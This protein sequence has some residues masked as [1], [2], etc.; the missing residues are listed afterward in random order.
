MGEEHPAGKNFV[1]FMKTFSSKTRN[2][3]QEGFDNI[4]LLKLHYCRYGPSQG[5]IPT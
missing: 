1:D 3:V 5:S 2:A 4:E